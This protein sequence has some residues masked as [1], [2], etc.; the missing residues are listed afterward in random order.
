MILSKSGFFCGFLSTPSGWRAT[1]FRSR[2]RRRSQFLS[3]PSGWRATNVGKLDGV[4]IKISIHALRVEGDSGRYSGRSRFHYFYP[5]PPG[6]GRPRRGA[7]RAAD[8]RF[9]STPSGW[10]AT[11]ATPSSCFLT[12]IFLSTPSGWRATSLLYSIYASGLFLSTPS[13]WRATSKFTTEVRWICISIHAL[14]V[15]G[16]YRCHCASLTGTRFLST[17]S[18]WRATN[19]IFDEFQS[20]QFLSTPSGWRATA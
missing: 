13:G 18:G 12:F 20:E 8:I 14:R 4:L 11:T 17:P 16:D 5:R 3:T 7:R 9:L 6:G 2:Y 10:R 15:E 19:I 1:G